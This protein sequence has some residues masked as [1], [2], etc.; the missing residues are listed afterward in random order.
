VADGQPQSFTQPEGIVE[1]V[2]CTISGAEP[3]SWCPSERTEIF[4]WDQLPNPKEEDLWQEIEI[5]T[6]TRLRANNYCDEFTIDEFAMNVQDK[7]AIEW[8]TGNS[9]G[10]SWAEDHGFDRPIFF[11]PENECDQ[12]TLRPTVELLSPS[13]NDQLVNEHVNIVI[14]VDASEHFFQYVIEFAYGLNPDD[15]D[16]EELF[17]KKNPVT[18]PTGVYNWDLRDLE[19]GWLSLRLRLRSDLDTYA[20]QVIALNIQVPTA[21]PTQTFTPSITPSPTH[22][23]T[24]S[25][26]APPTLAPTNTPAPPTNTPS[27]TATNTDTPGP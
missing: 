15:H 25:N 22:T 13:H 14:K 2:V 20:E 16:W 18:S 11:T 4:A 10:R 26:T 5:D 19:R 23:L 3:S 8:L 6:W 24:P 7:W 17:K 12:D 21:T 1:K 9:Q 27:S